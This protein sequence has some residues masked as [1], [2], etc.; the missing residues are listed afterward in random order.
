MRDCLQRYSR[1]CSYLFNA[2]VSFEEYYLILIL[3]FQTHQPFFIQLKL[4]LICSFLPP[5]CSYYDSYDL[6]FCHTLIS[7][8]FCPIHPLFIRFMM[9]QAAIVLKYVFWIAKMFIPGKAKMPA[10]LEMAYF[11]PP[12]MTFSFLNFTSFWGF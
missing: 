7:L 1:P 12:K 6:K 11:S 9:I 4:T 5:F 3:N 10:F 8:L 2:E